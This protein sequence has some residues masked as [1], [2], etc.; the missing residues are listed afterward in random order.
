LSILGR[1]GAGGEPDVRRLCAVAAETLEMTGAGIMLMA[2]DVHRGSL[3]ST[4]PVSALIEEQQYSLGEG[5]CVDAHESG[6][7]VMEPDLAHPLTARWVA[8][9]PPVIAVG[10]RAVFGFPLRVGAVRLGALNLYRDRAGPLS[11]VQHADALVMAEIAAQAVL[12]LQADATAGSLAAELERGV[13]LQLVVHQASGMVAVQLGASVGQALVRLRAHA[14]ANER[15]LAEVAADV[16][17]RRLRFEPN[18]D[19]NGPDHA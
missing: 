19:G 1:L 18:T 13:D 10:V 9:A 7:P 15:S 8:F 12:V 17:A 5:P 4:D 14:F 16:V 11:D 3:C 2:G 6:R